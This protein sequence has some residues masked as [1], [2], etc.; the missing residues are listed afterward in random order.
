MF[1]SRRELL[2]AI[3]LGETSHLELKEVRFT[4]NRVSAP[5]RD[6]FADGITAFA[7]SRGGVLVLG[8]ED[9][10]RDIIGIPRERL[11][12]VVDFVKEICSDSIKPSIEIVV[13]DRLALPSSA[14]HMVDVV[15]LEVPRSLFVHRGPSGYL[16]RVG[17]SKRIMSPEFLARLFQQRSQTRIIRFDEQPV[18]TAQISDLSAELWER[19]RTPRSDQEPETFL[20]KLGMA[21]QDGAGPPKPTV[22]G[23]L[24]GSDAPHDWLPNAYVQAVA[25][26][27]QG[28][29]AEAGDPAYQIDAADITGPLDRQIIGTCQFV[30]KNMRVSAVKSIGR[31]DLPQFDLSAV[32]EALVN[33]VAHRDYSVHGAKIR[34]R[35]FEDRLELYSPG[36]LANTLTV[37]SL[38][39]R[40]T[41]RN[42]TMCSLLSRC[43]VPDESWLTSSRAH[44][45]EK[46]GEGVPIILDNSTL[47]SGREP[48]YRVLDDAELMLTIFGADAT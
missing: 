7:N 1:D 35:M 40:Q 14:G 45:M 41:A 3:Q 24:M 22:A 9:K 23:M 11:D 42:E 17:D 10:S 19:F 30:F 28:I 6:D 4:G 47:L 16:H 2:D 12:T 18:A 13:I 20:V 38:R 39:Y 44:F 25:Y 43:P 21:A 15:K 46:R 48:E 36:S 8:V 37:E 27:G 29:G 32:F 33:A 26:R 5:T 31:V 34:L